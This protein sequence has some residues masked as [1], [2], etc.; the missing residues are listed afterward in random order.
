MPAESSAFV[1]SNIVLYA[2]GQE[3]HKKQQAWRILFNRP[4]I[5]TQVLGECSNV[6]IK[7]HKLD[8]SQIRG[9]LSDILLF[10][11]VEPIGLPVVET[12]WTVLERYR[13]SYFDSL[14]VASALTAG[15]KI[16]YSED[17]HHGQVIDGRL[18]I[19]NPFLGTI[20]SQ[21]GIAPE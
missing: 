1:D 16:L 19:I 21:N 20:D 5:S 14:I 10:T 7:K 11:T 8:K 13:Y 9:T 3:P 18:S 4:R 2:L 17:L 6:L 15:C 12:A